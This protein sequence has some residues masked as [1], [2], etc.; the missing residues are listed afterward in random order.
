MTYCFLLAPNSHSPDLSDKIKGRPPGCVLNDWATCAIG[1]GILTIWAD[2]IRFRFKQLP[3]H[4][5]S[6][7]ITLNSNHQEKK[8]AHLKLAYTANDLRT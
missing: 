8:Q 4:M 5:F 6:A 2:S 7:Y 1:Y 3:Q